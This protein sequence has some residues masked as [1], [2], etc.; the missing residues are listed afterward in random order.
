MAS[1]TVRAVLCSIITDNDHLDC[2]RSKAAKDTV[3]QFLKS[4]MKDACMDV[5]DEF[6]SNLVKELEKCF[7]SCVSSDVPFRSKHMKREKLWSCFQ[8]L[9]VN[10]L[11]KMWRDLFVHDIGNGET[12]PKLS[13]LVYQCVTQK[14]YSD[15][16]SC[17]LGTKLDIDKSC[18]TLSLTV[19]EHSSLCCRLCAI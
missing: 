14:L 19:D 18:K 10:K 5:F 7:F 12:I 1:G 9:R 17:H 11:G 6:A 16:I 13:P 4:V 15:I 2:E 8:S 3:K